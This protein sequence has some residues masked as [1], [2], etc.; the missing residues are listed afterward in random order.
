MSTEVVWGQ[1]DLQ[2]CRD[3]VAL[4]AA[5]IQLI[6]VGD[7]PWPGERELGNEMFTMT[8]VNHST[9]KYSTKNPWLRS[10][11]VLRYPDGFMGEC[12]CPFSDLAVVVE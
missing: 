1:D 5:K 12:P 11:H 9:A 3:L 4:E 2:Q 6:P 10:L 8:C 7:F